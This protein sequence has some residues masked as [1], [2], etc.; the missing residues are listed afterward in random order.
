MILQSPLDPKIPIDS[1]HGMADDGKEP[2][3]QPCV[4]QLTSP[5]LVRRRNIGTQAFLPRSVCR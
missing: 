3:D 4:F 2:F 1:L 5:L